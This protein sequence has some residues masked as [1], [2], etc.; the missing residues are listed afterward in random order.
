MRVRT[1]RRFMLLLL[2]PAVAACWLPR[3]EEQGQIPQ[4]EGIFSHQRH[5]AEDLECGDC[6]TE[7]A[8]SNGSSPELLP[9]LDVCESCHDLSEISLP[10]RLTA[11]TDAIRQAWFIRTETIFSHKA[12]LERG[13]EP[14]TACHE[15][16]E[17][18]KK[19]TDRFLPP[20]SRCLSCHRA[21]FVAGD[22]GMCH[23][24]LGSLGLEPI[25]AFSH[26]GEFLSRHGRLAR[27]SAA[28]C[29][30]CHD[31]ATCV[32]CHGRNTRL[33]VAIRRPERVERLL[34][35]RGDYRTRHP[36]EAHAEPAL[37]A[38]CHATVFCRD[39]HE[40]ERVAFPGTPDT[41]AIHPPGFSDPAAPAFHGPAARRDILSCAAC[42]DQGAESNCVPC[43]RVG[44]IAGNPHP[45]GWS[46]K[47]DPREDRVCLSCHR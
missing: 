4:E 2:L 32:A 31:A 38:K 24:D 34:I 10:A 1:E 23:R 33:T 20:M 47:L 21:R 3:N 41:P 5:I 25:A 12:H 43:H 45:P 18:S 26:D 44:G 27:A 46:T 9:D 39:C 29:L 11:S 8:Q 15:G 35:H 16:I 30:G 7:V 17:T 22:C 14:C 28:T 19:V 40:R 6:H 42:H 13:I 36:I 37:C